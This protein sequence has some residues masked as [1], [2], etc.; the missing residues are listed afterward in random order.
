MKARPIKGFSLWQ[1]LSRF[2]DK[3]KT[4]H[5]PTLFQNAAFELSHFYLTTL[6]LK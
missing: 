5:F 1:N 3:L 4:T 6:N 2:T